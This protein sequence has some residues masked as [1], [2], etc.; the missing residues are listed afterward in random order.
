MHK[1]EFKII[2]KN[3]NNNSSM[4]N[5]QNTKPNFVLILTDEERFPPEYERNDPEL[6]KLREKI[7]TARKFLTQSCVEFENHYTEATACTPARASIFTGK[8]MFEHG[9]D[10]TAGF[11]K[12]PGDP[13]L[14]WLSDDVTTLGH[15]MRNLGY[16]THYIGKWHLTEEKK[17]LESYGFSS[18]FGPEPHGPDLKKSGVVRDPIYINK[19]IEI[20]RNRINNNIQ[21]PFLLV[22]SLVNP[23]DIVLYS[24]LVLFMK[25]TNEHNFNF[26]D[27]PDSNDISTVAK[28]FSKKYR[29]LMM[30]KWFH[31]YVHSDKHAIKNFYFDMLV[32]SDIQIRRFLD[33][34][35]RTSYYKNTYTFFTSDHGEMLFTKNLMQKFFVPYQ[36]AIHVPFLIHHPN[37]STRVSYNCLTS[38]LDIIPTIIGLCKNNFNNQISDMY[39]RNLAAVIHE[40]LIYGNYVYK[41]SD[42]EHTVIFETKDDVFEGDTPYPLYYLHFPLLTKLIVKI[43]GQNKSIMCPK[44]IKTIISFETYNEKIKLFKLSK[45]YFENIE[46]WEMFNLSDDPNE[47]S[48]IINQTNTELVNILTILKEKM[49]VKFKSKL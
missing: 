13:K 22:I 10:K 5:E 39:G 20:L 8:P 45:Y 4:Y 41:K 36:E 17:D 6:I 42:I 48:N 38:S 14:K 27:A 24:K 2:K 32:K 28:I 46:E 21:K 29:T 3:I 12:Q 26:P 47:T 44:Y 15:V 25:Q 1:R 11:D 19:A 9:I 34:F 18:W 7:L 40:S 16:D 30:P 23:H 37:I 35:T 49:I 33:F 31:D 43:F